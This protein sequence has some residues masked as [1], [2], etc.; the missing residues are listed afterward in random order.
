MQDHRPGSVCKACAEARRQRKAAKAA[1][2]SPNT[3]AG[4]FQSSP[5]Q[6]PASAELLSGNAGTLRPT[7]KGAG[8]SKKRHRDAN[9]KYNHV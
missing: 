9:G 4:L 5:Q 7:K 3:S 8:L 2:N 1:A 6:E